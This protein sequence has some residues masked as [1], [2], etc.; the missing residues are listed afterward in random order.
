MAMPSM[1]VRHPGDSLRG[2][3][4]FS[5]LLLLVLTLGLSACSVSKFGSQFTTPTVYATETPDSTV[6]AFE[7]VDL[8]WLDRSRNRSV[9]VRLY[10]PKEPQGKVV[11]LVIFSHGI[12]G[13][14][15]GYSYLGSYWASHGY[16]SMHVQHVGS[17]R[18]LWRGNVFELVPRLQNAAQDNEAIERVRDLHFALDT[19]LSG[20][21][22]TRIDPAHIVAAGH[23]YGANTV[24]LAAGARVVRNGT[25]IHYRDERITAAILLSAPPFYGDTDMASILAGVQIPTL[26]ITCTDDTISIPGYESPASDR[27]KVFEAIG[28]PQKTLVM[29]EGGSHSIFTDRPVTGGV[30]LNPQIKGATQTLS[31]AFLHRISAGE[32]G[33]IAAWQKENKTLLSRFVG[34]DEERLGVIVDVKK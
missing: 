2:V 33:E 14:R 4:R 23:S 22:G 27:L 26:H 13:S 24:L 17:D 30:A 16:A 3:P 25:L 29:F 31:L 20:E 5:F 8:D 12:G 18:S 34:V 15:K 10:L 11:P 6:A 28:S 1:R 21:Y 9:P 19:V 7:V 32:N